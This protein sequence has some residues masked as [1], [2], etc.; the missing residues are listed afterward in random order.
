MR[1]RSEDVSKRIL[2]NLEKKYPDLLLYIDNPYTEELV[3]AS[4]DIFAQIKIHL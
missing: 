1:T 4:I 2:N 3:Q